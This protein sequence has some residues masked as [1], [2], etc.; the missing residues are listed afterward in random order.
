[1]ADARLVATN[2]DDSSLVPVACTS[3]GLLKTEP[4]GEGPQGPKGDPGPP[5]PEGVGV[6]TIT[7]GL[8]GAYLRVVGNQAAWLLDGTRW[9]ASWASDLISSDGE[10][11]S[12]PYNRAFDGR[13]NTF[14]VP[15][16]PGFGTTLTLT[17]TTNF[18][19]G[20]MEV[21]TGP[22]NSGTE[23]YRYTIAGKTETFTAPSSADVWAILHRAQNT[24][25]TVGDTFTIESSYWAY[26]SRIRINGLLLYDPVNSFSS[27]KEKFS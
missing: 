24:Q 11:A 27:I 20:L 4:K 5:G 23:T 8:N 15:N 3:A 9:E 12:G 18:T 26:L 19:I 6:P 22:S 7:S 21:S 13:A 14:A 1:M 2:P 17:F 10:N 25:I 16:A